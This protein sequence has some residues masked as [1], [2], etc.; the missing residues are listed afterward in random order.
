MAIYSNI[1]DI[2]IGIL[3]INRV[4]ETRR[5]LTIIHRAVYEF[6]R[7]KSHDIVFELRGKR[8]TYYFDEIRRIDEKQ[9]EQ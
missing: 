7:Y 4:S 6:R 3:V 2:S 5:S 8:P 1:L 9:G